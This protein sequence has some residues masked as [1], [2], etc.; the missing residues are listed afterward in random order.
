MT[1]TRYF[2]LKEGSKKVNGIVIKVRP[3]APLEKRLSEITGAT[4]RSELCYYSLDSKG[5]ED[6]QYRVD[7]RKS[8]APPRAKI[9]VVDIDSEGTLEVVEKP[10]INSRIY[11]SEISAKQARALVDEAEAWQL[12][13]GYMDGGAS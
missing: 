13:Q 2:N 11:L 12:T 9:M 7:L 10:R 5:V 8:F 4:F 6:A 1:K 3:N